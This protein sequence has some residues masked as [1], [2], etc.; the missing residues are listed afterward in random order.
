MRGAEGSVFKHTGK[1]Y[2]Q[3]PDTGYEVKATKMWTLFYMSKKYAYRLKPRC[4]NCV[5]LSVKLPEIHYRILCNNIVFCVPWEAVVAC[6]PGWPTFHSTPMLHNSLIAF[7]VLNEASTIVLI[8]HYRGLRKPSNEW[9]GNGRIE[10]WTLRQ[11][12]LAQSS[13]SIAASIGLHRL[14]RRWLVSSYDVTWH[15][16][17]PPQ[18]LEW[19]GVN[20]TSAFKF[21]IQCGGTLS[22]CLARCKA[23]FCHLAR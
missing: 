14:R 6:L 21:V 15:I 8:S 12:H 20:K 23:C 17:R 7:I 5:I 13:S 19:R 11:S 3:I 22:F 2:T 9:L 1:L 18:T 10:W 16:I 4:K